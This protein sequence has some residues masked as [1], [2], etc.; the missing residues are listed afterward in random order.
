M[1]LFATATIAFGFQ[2]DAFAFQSD[3]L[4]LLLDAI[5]F[6]P[7][8]RELLALEPFPV[9]AVALHA[10]VL[11]IEMAA[12]TPFVIPITTAM[13]EMRT[14]KSG[15]CKDESQANGDLAVHGKLQLVD[16][17]KAIKLWRVF[18]AAS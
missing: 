4:P 13:I 17:W 10:L 15:G 14:G 7:L 8:L 18:S 2:P 5:R 9:A 3:P 12:V 16:G 6:P 1:I 11:A